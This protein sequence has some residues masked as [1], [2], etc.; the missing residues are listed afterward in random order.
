MFKWYG[1]LGLF[2]VVFAE[3]TMFLRIFPIVFLFTPMVWFGY[4]FLVDAIVYKIRWNSLL[5]SNRKKFITLFILSA[6]FWWIFEFINDLAKVQGWYYVNL[7]PSTAVTLVIGTLSF[8]TILPAVFETWHLIQ[9]FNLFR[10]TSLRLKFSSNKF[11]VSLIFVVGILFFI[12]PFVWINPWIWTFV[13]LGFILLLDPILYLFGD[14]KSLL[15]QV[16]KHRFNMLISLFVAGYITGFFWEFWN[17][18]AYTKWYYTIPV[19]ENIRVF[20]IPAVGFL[21]YGPFALELYVMYH[22]ARFLLHHPHGQ[23]LIHL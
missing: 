21:A 7:P 12:F 16:K 10:H 18:W 15:F 19:L 20:E 5:M 2:L 9:S 17:Y 4:I 23:H 11:L 8:A 13:W 6:I 22:F 1:L 14:E 3:V